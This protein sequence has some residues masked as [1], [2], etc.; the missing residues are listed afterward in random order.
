MH[1][2]QI[3]GRQKPKTA[4]DRCPLYRMNVFAPNKVTAKSRFWYY[5]SFMRKVNK[6]HGEVVSCNKIAEKRPNVVKNYGIWVR[7]DSRT[8]SHNMYREYRDTHL[9]RAV[10]RCYQDMSARHRAPFSRIQIVRTAIIPASKC[11]RR[12]VQEYLNAKIKF[13]LHHRVIRPSSIRHRTTFKATRP[14]TVFGN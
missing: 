2:Y 8:G 14:H 4:T 7:Y 10:N 13:P 1:Y 3:V 6:S 11:R 12:G 5:V 9:S